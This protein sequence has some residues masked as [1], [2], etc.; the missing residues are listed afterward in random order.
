MT[1]RLGRTHRR[2]AVGIIVFVAAASAR[3]AGAIGAGEHASKRASIATV[4]A[5]RRAEA[6]VP[7]EAVGGRAPAIRRRD[8][9]WQRPHLCHLSQRRTGTFSPADASAGWRGISTT[10]VRAR[11]PG[12]WRAGHD[13][14][15]GARDVGIEI[16]LTS[17]V[18][19]LNDPAATSVVYLCAGRRPRSTRGVAAVFMYDGRDTSLEE[20]ALGAIQAHAQNGIE[21]TA[22]SCN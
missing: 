9:R 10:A 1:H 3:L 14:H 2:F 20:Q 7:G 12:R 16:S 8:F 5:S 21:P 6:L 11:R 17:R 18:K 19:L 13:P 4:P 22:L 15:N